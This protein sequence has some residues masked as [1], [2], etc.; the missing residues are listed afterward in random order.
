MIPRTSRGPGR[1]DARI[2]FD[3]EEPVDAVVVTE[4]SK[5]GAQRSGGPFG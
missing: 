4:Y 1:E 3:E 5:A 2:D